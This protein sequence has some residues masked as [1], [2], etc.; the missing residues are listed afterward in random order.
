MGL[1]VVSGVGLC[2]EVFILRMPPASLPINVM[3]IIIAVVSCAS[4]LEASGGLKC[5]LQYAERAA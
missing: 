5:M 4:I 1:G 3:L 2:I